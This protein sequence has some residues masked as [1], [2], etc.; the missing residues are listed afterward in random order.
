[1]SKWIKFKV[2]HRPIAQPR[3]RFTKNGRPYRDSHH[4]VHAYRAQIV[5]AARGAWVAAPLEG[6]ISL[7]VVAVMPRRKS[8]QWKTR[9]TPA[10]RHTK[11]PDIDNLMK[12]VMDAL[13]GVLYKDDA[14]V[15]EIYVQKVVAP[16]GQDPH[17]YV[18]VKEMSETIAE[19]GVD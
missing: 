8:E 16:G 9:P 18:T 10:Y 6:P 14:Q 3:Q 1:M 19:P 2:E 11:R 7:T 4:P 15:C 5:T 13:N 12:A 17:T